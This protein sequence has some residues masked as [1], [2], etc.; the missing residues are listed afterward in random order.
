M[1]WRPIE[2]APKDGTHILVWGPDSGGIYGFTVPYQPMV[3]LWWKDDGR[4]VARENDDMEWGDL[5][6]W[7]PLPELPAA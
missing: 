1:D 4:W 7:M 2:T 3:V 6:H 5:T